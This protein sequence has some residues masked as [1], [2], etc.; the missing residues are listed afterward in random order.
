MALDG[1]TATEP[2]GFFGLQGVKMEL[3]ATGS[4]FGSLQSLEVYTKVLSD[5]GPV[6]ENPDAACLESL[7]LIWCASLLYNGNLLAQLW[8]SGPR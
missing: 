6:L 5:V 8:T 4:D 3:P 1:A 2:E 7:W